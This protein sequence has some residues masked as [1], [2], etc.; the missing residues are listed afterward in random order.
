M[1]KLNNI[2]LLSIINTNTI[3]TANAHGFKSIQG[4]Q[5]VDARK[6]YDK[7]LTGNIVAK[8]KRSLKMVCDEAIKDTVLFILQRDNVNCYGG[9]NP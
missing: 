8:P 9:T 4:Q 7:I 1:A 5:I 6:T 3:Y 2:K